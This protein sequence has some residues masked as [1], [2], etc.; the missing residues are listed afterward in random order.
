MTRRV[1]SKRCSK[2]GVRSARVRRLRQLNESPLAQTNFQLGHLVAERSPWK[3]GVD[4]HDVALG[5]VGNLAQD[6]FPRA[7]G[8]R[9]A[10][11]RSARVV[12]PSLAQSEHLAVATKPV[13]NEMRIAIGARPAW[14]R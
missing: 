10:D 3:R 5:P 2:R 7:V 6:V 9:E 12:L 1:C 4:A 14:P 13:Q 11:E 8:L